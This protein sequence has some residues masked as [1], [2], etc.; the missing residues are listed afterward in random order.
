MVVDAQGA[1][2]SGAFVTVVSASQP[3][4]EMAL[5][6]ADD[7]AVIVHLPAGPVVLQADHS[8][9][10]ARAEAALAAGTGAEIEIVLD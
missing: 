1:P 9:R 4:P 3:V 8:G 5:R 7:G 6:T 10:Q 2:V